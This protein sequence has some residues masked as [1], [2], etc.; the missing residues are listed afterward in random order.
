MLHP[1]H[2]SASEGTDMLVSARCEELSVLGLAGK[3]SLADSQ[4]SIL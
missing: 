4:V 2:L 3:N 1:W